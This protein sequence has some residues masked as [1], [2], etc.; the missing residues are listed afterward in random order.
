MN[1]NELNSIFNR[2]EENMTDKLN[3]HMYAGR[4]ECVKP[5]AVKIIEY[6]N[7]FGFKTIA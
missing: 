2:Y 3:T 1:K 7:I 4:N 6:Q 5:Q